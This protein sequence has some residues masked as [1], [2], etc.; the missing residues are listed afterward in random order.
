MRN[1]ETIGMPYNLTIEGHGLKITPPI[2]EYIVNK[3][4]RPMR[5]FREV[6]SVTV[7]A[8]CESAPGRS[9]RHAIEVTVHLKGENIFLKKVTDDLYQA[10]DL[11]MDSLNRKIGECKARLQHHRHPALKRVAALA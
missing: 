3:L 5:H 2:R 10:V 7:L 4:E 9:R 8:R 1:Q 6:V 11:L